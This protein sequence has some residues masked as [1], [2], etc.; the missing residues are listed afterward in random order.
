MFNKSITQ[1]KNFIKLWTSQALTTTSLNIVNYALLLQLFNK[2]NST[3]A[4]SFLWL[5]YSLPVLL[6]G[7]FA[8]TVVDLIN[9]K[10]LLMITTLLQSGIVLLFLPVTDK[11]FLLYA[12]MF[13]YSFSSQFYLPSESATLPSIVGK[14]QLPEANGMF[15]LTK[16][17]GL[18]IGYGSAGFLSKFLGIHPTFVLCSVLLFI[19]FISVTRL[20]NYKS[21]RKIN[22]EQDL[23]HFF[24]KVADGY[25]FIK[26]NKH[27][28]YPILL[29][30]GGEIGLVIIGVNIPALAK[31]ILNIP[32]E[33][34]ALYIILPGILGAVIAVTAI[35]KILKRGLRKLRMIRTALFILTC[36][37][38]VIGT[39]LVTIPYSLRFIVLPIICFITGIGYI[40]VQVPAQ[41]FLQETT[42]QDFMGRIWGNLWFLTTLATIVP[43][44]F[45]ASITE[46]LGANTLFILLAI[47][48]GFVYLF[49]TKKEPLQ[50][51]SPDATQKEG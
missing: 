28:L 48:V 39:A 49:T 29:I 3:L 16:E 47:G 12:V 43:M 37:L 51:P 42:P 35:P 17:M 33:D 4:A 26:N 22:L 34:A 30:A 1:N 5:A 18:L 13:L 7:P 25:K 46:F 31:E 10:K 41:T 24:E 2:T 38:F 20:P 32:V 45:S 27:V 15:L 36:C 21:E 11:F 40:G 6:V 14:E 9:R 23:S 44:I 19:A 8:A 50:I